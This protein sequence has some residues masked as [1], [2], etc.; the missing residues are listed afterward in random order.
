MPK[1]QKKRQLPS[2][3]AR[4][5]TQ[6]I[7]AAIGGTQK[8]KQLPSLLARR[9]A[10]AAIGGKRRSSRRNRKITRKMTMN[11]IAQRAISAHRRIT[12][13]AAAAAGA[14]IG[15]RRRRK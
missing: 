4:R 12:S 13:A 3:L 15:G 9:G 14:G 2:L 7:A 8:K 11:Q 5:G 1:T 6:S 10:A